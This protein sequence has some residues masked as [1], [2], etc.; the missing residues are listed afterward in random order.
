MWRQGWGWV[1]EHPGEYFYACSL[2]CFSVELHFTVTYFHMTFFHLIQRKNEGWSNISVCVR[3]L[4][5]T[6]CFL[7]VGFYESPKKNKK[8]SLPI[9]LQLFGSWGQDRFRNRAWWYLQLDVIFIVFTLQRGRGI[10]LYLECLAWWLSIVRSISYVAVFWGFFLRFFFT[11]FHYVH[12]QRIYS[13]VLSATRVLDGAASSCFMGI[14]VF[15]YLSYFG[16]VILSIWW[17]VSFITLYIL[18]LNPDSLSWMPGPHSFDLLRLMFFFFMVFMVYF[19]W[20]PCLR[21]LRLYDFLSCENEL[22]FMPLR[23]LA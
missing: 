11:A 16:V 15:S 17:F 18:T 3:G 10:S 8:H 22:F 14:S 23:A 6:R 7:R 4:E 1:R 12:I 9:Y 5:I 19:L 20:S 2:R 13:T 21:P